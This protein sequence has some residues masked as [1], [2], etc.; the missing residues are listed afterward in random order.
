MLTSY[1]WLIYAPSGGLV[2]IDQL[3]AWFGVHWRCE[4][5]PLTLGGLWQTAWVWPR[6]GQRKPAVGERLVQCG[7]HAVF[8]AAVGAYATSET[9]LAAECF[10]SLAP[11]MLARRLRVCPRVVKR[12]MSRLLV[13]R[14]AHRDC[15]QTL[16]RPV[17]ERP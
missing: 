17:A 9:K 12:K 4:S 8:D 1:R 10:D 2:S 14:K 16:P 13:K 5:I 3:S 7:A 15:Q 11:R 6:P